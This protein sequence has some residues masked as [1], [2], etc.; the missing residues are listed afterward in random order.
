MVFNMC[1]VL[2]SESVTMVRILYTCMES[3]LCHIWRYAILDI[4]LLNDQEED[5]CKEE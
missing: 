5:G 3:I 2:D 1:I 4:N